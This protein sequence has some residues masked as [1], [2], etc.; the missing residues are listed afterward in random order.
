MDQLNLKLKRKAGKAGNQLMT[1]S[2]LMVCEK[3]TDLSIGEIL[4][5]LFADKGGWA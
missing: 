2:R 3:R 4:V 5:L 1:L